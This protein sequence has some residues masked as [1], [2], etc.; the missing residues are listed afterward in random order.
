MSSATA[1]QMHG[2]YHLDSTQYFQMPLTA[3]RHGCTDDSVSL[4]HRDPSAPVRNIIRHMLRLREDYPVLRDGAFLQQ[5][6]NQT[7][8]VYYPGSSGIATETGMWSVLRSGYQ[9]VQ[10]ISGTT[11]D[12]NYIW[13]LYSNLNETRTWN[14]DCEDDKFDLN[15]TALISP[16]TV[17]THS[18]AYV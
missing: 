16:Y 8:N 17:S 4:D 6:S 2:C 12:T 15:S 11:T 5:L 10:N 1:W 3:A 7:E 14:F 9:G 13:L 18:D